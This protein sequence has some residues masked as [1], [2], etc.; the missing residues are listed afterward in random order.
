MYLLTPSRGKFILDF[1]VM[2]RYF[3]G[4]IT[5]A[6]GA[7]ISSDLARQLYS[8]M[9]KHEQKG[10]PHKWFSLFLVGG[11]YMVNGFIQ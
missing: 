4:L 9:N 8:S 6:R 11:D 5:L 10:G 7:L 2:F 3:Y 1:H